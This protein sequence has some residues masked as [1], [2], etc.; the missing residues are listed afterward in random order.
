MRLRPFLAV[1]VLAVSMSLAG[2]MTGKA[3]PVAVLDALGRNYAHCERTVSYAA[4]VGPVNPS[5]GA[6][7]NGTVRCPAQPTP[8][9]VGAVIQ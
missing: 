7:I 2:C 6:T 9:A 8:L 4:T 3:D 1:A 5:S